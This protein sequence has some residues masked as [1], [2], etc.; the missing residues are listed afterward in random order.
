MEIQGN[1]LLIG[2]YGQV[3]I[4]A[5]YA[6]IIEETLLVDRKYR[7]GQY[8]VEFKGELP[9]FRVI[10]E[11]QVRAAIAAYELEKDNGS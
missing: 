6:H 9:E 1:Y 2:G 10:P 8:Q 5:K 3:L 7:D 4:P 11:R